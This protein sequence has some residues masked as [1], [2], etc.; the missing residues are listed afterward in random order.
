[1]ATK[2]EGISLFALNLGESG[3]DCA[4]LGLCMNIQA[5]R[6]EQIALFTALTS[7]AT[8]VAPRIGQERMPFNGRGLT[9]VWYVCG[10]ASLGF[11]VG[12]KRRWRASLLRMVLD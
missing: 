7:T 10:P 8:A 9:T 12:Y 11:T 4:R 3:P 2:D 5:S 6:Q 1:V